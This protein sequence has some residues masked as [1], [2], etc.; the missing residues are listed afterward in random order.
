MGSRSDGVLVADLAN[1]RVRKSSD[2]MHQSALRNKFILS[3]FTNK[4]GITWVG[5]S[6]VGVSKYDPAI[7]QFELFRNDALPGKPRW[8]I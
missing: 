1:Y 2:F 8:I 3:F 4:Q 5:A 7:T 6:G